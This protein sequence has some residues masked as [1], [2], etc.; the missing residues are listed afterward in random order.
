[1]KDASAALVAAV[2]NAVTNHPDFAFKSRRYPQLSVKRRLRPATVPSLSTTKQK[3]RAPGGVF[4]VRKGAGFLALALML[5]GSGAWASSTASATKDNASPANVMQM[6]TPF[7]IATAQTIHWE[8]TYTG[9]P[10]AGN[11]FYLSTSGDNMADIPLTISGGLSGDAFLNPRKYFI[12]I[13]TS[14]MGPGTFKNYY[15]TTPTIRGRAPPR[16]IPR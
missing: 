10:T 2:K 8:A 6:G 4:S 5:C 14:P 12:T 9:G 1:M 7:A 3:L 15:H 11:D 13:P 16:T